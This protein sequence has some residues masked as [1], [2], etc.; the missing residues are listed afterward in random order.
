MMRV[1]IAGNSGHGLSILESPESLEKVEVVGYCRTYEGERLTAL[2]EAFGDLHKELPFY[3]DYR[4]MLD[5]TKPDVVVVDGMFCDHAGLAIEALK[6]EMHVYCEKPLATEAESLEEMRQVL[7][8]GRGKIFAMQ[9]LRYLSWFYTAKQLADEGR[10][11]DV[12]M[13]NVQKSYKLG[14][15]EA[16]FKNRQTYGGTIPWVAIHGIDL[17]LW[18]TGRRVTG[19]QAFQSKAYNFNHGDLETTAVCNYMLEDEIVAN[20]Q[21]DY[22]RV[23]TAPGHSDDRLRIVGTK[24]TIEVRTDKVFLTNQAGNEQVIPLL[25]PPVMFEDFLGYLKGDTES[26]N[27][28]ESSL[29]TTEIALLTRQAAESGK[30]IRCEVPQRK[31]T[32]DIIA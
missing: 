9:S 14:K 3:Q 6:R 24:G 19:L 12:R 11:G 2:R 23:S 29:Y 30:L 20:L 15:R 7:A 18:I 27:N 22:Y 21:A 28:T 25:A 32:S 1:C 10:V 26:L 4:Q 31:G 16:F 5:E 13:I 8:A 17:I